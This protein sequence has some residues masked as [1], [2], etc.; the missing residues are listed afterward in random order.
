MRQDADAKSIKI[1]AYA[2]EHT[3][4]EADGA[5]GIV[6]GMCIGVLVIAARVEW[7]NL[8]CK[9]EVAD[10]TMVVVLRPSV[11]TMGDQCATIK[12]LF[13]ILA[14]ALT[15]QAAACTCARTASTLAPFFALCLTH[16]CRSDNWMAMQRS[17]RAARTR[18]WQWARCGAALHC[19]RVSGNEERVETPDPHLACSPHKRHETS[20]LYRG[21][22]YLALP[23]SLLGT[24]GQCNRC[25]GCC[26][27]KTGGGQS[28]P[29][30]GALGSGKRAR[31][32]G[33]WPL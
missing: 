25:A 30:D 8:A 10:N 1:C 2:A 7:R 24:R 29:S 31:A 14:A 3:H 4:Q 33:G 20:A 13:G 12:R 16:W 18:T 32:S 27:R 23:P 15:S 11:N 9:D 21:A 28:V 19:E 22:L 26:C 5:F 6:G 17:A